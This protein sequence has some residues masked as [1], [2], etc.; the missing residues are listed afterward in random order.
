MEDVVGKVVEF[1]SKHV[2]V[3]GGEPLLQD[4][5]HALMRE[6]C[7]KGFVVSLETGGSLPIDTVDAR[8]H[9]I[10]DLKCPGSGMHEKNLW[11]NMDTLQKHHEVKF[12]I[13]D[14][15][16][17]AFAKDVCARYHLYD[18]VHSVLFAPVFGELDPQQL[19]G[20]IL[21]DKLPVRLNLQVHKWIWEPDT[22]GV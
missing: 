10:L 20:W 4:S 3:T 11:E 12:V 7:D 18:K 17:Y 8:V 22:M 9:V 15:A 1:G 2:C 13:A 14:K 5:V 6:L 16:D 21:E 19:V